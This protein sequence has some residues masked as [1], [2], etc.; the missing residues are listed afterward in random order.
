[1]RKEVALKVLH[2]EMT[3]LPE[4]VARF[5]RE[6]VAAA[7]IEHPN[8]VQAR[9]F[10]SLQDGS[11]YLVLE[12]V[13]GACLSDELENGP[14]TVPRALLIAGQVAEALAA[15]HEQNIVHRDLKPD[16][17]M[18]VP[19]SGDADVVKVLDFG[20]AK[21]AGREKAGADRPITR[22]GV[23]F[24]TPEYMSPEQAAGQT[25]DY[26]GDVYSVG[27]LLY[28]MIT[29]K[30]PFKSEEVSALLMMQITQPP[31]PLPEGVPD[32]VRDLLDELLQKR[33][34]DR[35][36]SARS[37]V[38]RIASLLDDDSAPPT[39]R[40]SSSSQSTPS[41]LGQ[42]LRFAGVSL[43][44][45]K[46]T[47]LGAPLLVAGAAL[48]FAFAP[49]QDAVVTAVA[50][51]VAA[52]DPSAD[53]AVIEPPLDPEA[54]KVVGQAFAGHPSAIK[55]LKGRP[56]AELTVR[57]WLAL[58]RGLS[59]LRKDADALHAYREALRRDLTVGKD[60][61]LRKDV[62]NATR[63]AT[64]AES[65]L[66]IAAEFLGAAGADLLY[67]TWVETKEVNDATTLAKRLVYSA[68]VKKQASPALSFVLDWRRAMSCEEFE[69]LLPTAS[70]HGDQRALTLL[71]RA[72]RDN[73]CGL[74][75][76][77]LE[78]AVRAVQERPPP[79]PY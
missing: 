32:S 42:P 72:L 31:P 78:A 56:A 38:E 39:R 33:P 44:L 65:A 57:Q 10:G 29:G 45:W 7:R 40:R 71:Q 12:Y 35:P 20:I 48:V 28:H 23:V 62:Y 15:A 70:L 8:V 41:P 53:A 64:T 9:D 58:G 59:K 22:A 49:R 26:R 66:K 21:V 46:F 73:D 68:E 16:N 25:V 36:Q 60:P 50:P 3:S 11:F 51:P 2:R 69:R 54:E 5:E 4:V 17:V 61:I 43:P 14:M 18:I 52:V 47:L 37:V 13:E 67:S 6:A 74:A 27:V 55:E 75:D 24:G 1:M 30:P 34:E 76:D 77:V 19:R 79:R 63:R